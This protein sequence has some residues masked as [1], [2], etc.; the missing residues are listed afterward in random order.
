MKYATAMLLS[1]LLAAMIPAGV[2]RGEDGPRREREGERE[3]EVD[4]HRRREG[5]GERRREGERKRD[6]EGEGRR[7]VDGHRRRE[8]EGERRREGQGERRPEGQGEHRRPREGEARSETAQLRRVLDNIMMRLGRMERELAEL[9]RVNADLRRRLGRPDGR[10]GEGERRREGQGDRR[11]EGEGERRREG[12]RKRDGEGERKK[13]VDGH[14]RREGEGERR[15]RAAAGLPANIKGFQGV[16]EGVIVR[17]SERG[18]VLKV[19]KVV[20]T[21]PQNRAPNARTVAGREVQVLIA[22]D[23]AVSE[24]WMALTKEHF[25]VLGTVKAG[26]RAVVEAFH[27]GGGH[28]TVVEQFRKLS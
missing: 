9:R 12:D 28:L 20:K 27:F 6:G 26:D 3:K 22:A 1:A 25:K 10:D 4:G 14:R 15:E 11:R 13:E 19:T 24:R 17:K 16:L 8:G 23:R 7:E 5:E 21:W 18:F 2:L